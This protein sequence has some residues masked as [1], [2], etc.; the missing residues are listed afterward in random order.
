MKNNVKV[1]LAASLV[2][3]AAAACNKPAEN[4][5]TNGADS[6][7]TETTTPDTTTAPVDTTAT[8][9]DTTAVKQ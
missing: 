3:F 1:L 6:I 7:Q 4:A 9:A 2:A 8:S 5:D